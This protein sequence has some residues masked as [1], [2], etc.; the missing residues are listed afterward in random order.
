M[1]KFHLTTVIPSLPLRT[2]IDS[3]LILQPAYQRICSAARAKALG[4]ELEEEEDGEKYLEVW[5][6][7]E[8]GGGKEEGLQTLRPNTEMMKRMKATI[9]GLKND[10]RG[11]ELIKKEKVKRPRY[12]RE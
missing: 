6:E 11:F 10:E 7:I 12:G 5:E 8:E 4:N 2:E 3:E 9:E 1:R